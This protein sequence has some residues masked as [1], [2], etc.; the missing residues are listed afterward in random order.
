RPLLLASAVWAA[1]LVV[2]SGRVAF[3]PRTHTVYPIFARAGHDWRSGTDLF[4]EPPR[5]GIDVYRYSPFA[6]VVFVPFSLLPDA[7]GGVLWR[8]L[9]A[10]LLLGGFAWGTR[11]VLPVR[12]SATQTAALWLLLVPLSLPSLNNAQS[13]V[14]VMGLLL[15]AVAG[16][17]ERR[18]NLAAVC[19]AVAC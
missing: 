14:H 11:R 15:I 2:I 3:S 5:P 6:A 1:V 10:A 8:L 13:N 9:G 12:L 16:A 17:A 7:I 4:A 18:W 19:V